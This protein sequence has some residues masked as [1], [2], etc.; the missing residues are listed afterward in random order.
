[1]NIYVCSTVR[2]LLFALCRANHENRQQHHILFFA[3]YQQTS[4]DDWNTGDLPP[5]I[6]IYELSRNDFRKKLKNTELGWLSYLF[7]MR[8]IPAPNW[9]I[10]PITSTL[11]KFAPKLV[12][13]MGDATEIKLWLFN[14]RNKMARLFRLLTPK[15]SNIEEGEGNY[16]EW[17]IPW[18]K[19]PP[20]LLRGLPLSYRASGDDPRCEE[21][22]V[23]DP[24]R[25]PPFIRSKGRQIN[26]LDSTDTHQLITNIFGNNGL[27]AKTDD[28]VILATQPLDV[29]REVTL[30]DKQQIY[31][32]IVAYLE[33]QNWKII[34]KIHPFENEADYTFLADRTITAHGKLP[35]EAI[36]LESQ[37][38][39]LIISI[40]SSAGL[41]FEKFCARVMLCESTDYADAIPLWAKRPEALNATLERMM[42]NN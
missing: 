34:L 30:Q 42:S 40:C 2:H 10:Q 23:L 35:V 25:L 16:H 26:F 18:W 4:L 37:K 22:W 1:M 31:E 29:L 14:E 39:I 8:Q 33:K 24:D 38:P 27:I 6:H 21:I 12:Q 5:N 13:A 11:E 32:Q 15:F 7:A 41:G 28:A 17:L 19:A 36:V 3:D 20:R 9:I